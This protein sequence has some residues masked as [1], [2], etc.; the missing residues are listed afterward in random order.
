MVTKIQMWKKSI[1]KSKN[2]SILL[3]QNNPSAQWR[4]VRPTFVHSTCRPELH[5]IW[6]LVPA[7]DTKAPGMSSDP[8]DTVST[9]STWSCRYHKHVFQLILQ[10]LWAL[11]GLALSSHASVMGT[12]LQHPW[13]ATRI[14]ETEEQKG[15][16]GRHLQLYLLTYSLLYCWLSIFMFTQCHVTV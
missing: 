2:A 12:R 11:V 16:H 5:V 8:A 7:A 13:T 14:T 15:W 4:M 6:S 1:T 10:I 3:V 9:S